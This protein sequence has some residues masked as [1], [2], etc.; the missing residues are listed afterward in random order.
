MAAADFLPLELLRDQNQQVFED[1]AKALRTH[2]KLLEELLELLLDFAQERSRRRFF[3][4]FVIYFQRLFSFVLVL[5]LKVLI[6][7]G[8]SGLLLVE[9]EIE[10]KLRQGLFGFLAVEL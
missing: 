1:L 4:V 2:V 8:F 9:D 7:L 5:D 10:E 3:L 6:A